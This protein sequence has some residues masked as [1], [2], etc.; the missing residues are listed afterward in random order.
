MELYI[1]SGWLNARGWIDLHYYNVSIYEVRNISRLTH[2]RKIHTLRKINWRKPIINDKNRPSIPVGYCWLVYI[3]ERR[4]PSP[5]LWGWVCGGVRGDSTGRLRENNPTV[6][7]DELYS[8]Q[9]P[10]C[11]K[12]SRRT[13]V[14][15]EYYSVCREKTHTIVY[16]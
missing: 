6:D 4:G 3:F 13:V 9:M 12:K 8:V 7:I 10:N 2:H 1:S 11:E 14:Y 5:S 16:I 15:T